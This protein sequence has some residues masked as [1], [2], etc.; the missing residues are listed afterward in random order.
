LISENKF[1]ASRYGLH[2]KLIDFGKEE[3]LPTKKLMLEYLHMIDEVVDELGSRDEI[4]YIHEMLKMGTGADRQLKVFHETGDLK[5]V[6]DYIVEETKVG[7]F[8]TAPAHK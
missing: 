2:G 3:E 5:K 7:I 1:R 4:D 6:V 8:D